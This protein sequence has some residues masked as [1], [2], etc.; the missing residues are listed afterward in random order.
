[1]KNIEEKVG[2]RI[3]WESWEKDIAKIAQTYTERINILLEKDDFEI[4]KIFEDFVNGLKKNLNDSITRDDAI[5]MLS[6]HLITKPVFDALF[7]EYEFV[8]NNPV[9]QA[10]QDMMEVFDRQSLDEEKE[11]LQK[12]YDSVRERVKGIDNIDGKQKIIIELY[13]KFFKVAL[14]KEVEKLGIVYTPTECVDFIVNSVETI[15]NKEFNKSLSDRGIHIM[16]GFTGTG[17]FIVRLLQSGIIKKEDLLYKYTNEIYANEIVLLAYYIAVINIEEVFHDLMEIDIYIPF[18]G[19]VLTD[20]FQLYE[21][22]KKEQSNEIKMDILPENSERARKQKELPITVIMGNPPYS[23]GQKNQDDNAKNLK[24]PKLDKQISETYVKYSNTSLRRNLYD[25]Y[26]R[27]FRWAS[28]RILDKGVICFISNASFI[29]SNTMNGFRKCIIDE[30]TSIYI[31]NLRGN[32]RMSGETSRKEGGKIFGSGSRTPV[33]ITCL[34]KN[35]NRKN[36]GYIHY[37]DIGDYLSR[38]E[39]LF[40]IS[41][42]NNI[43]NIEWKKIVP[44]KN[45]DWI[46]KRNKLFKHLYPLAPDKKC[47]LSTKSVFTNYVIGTVSSRDAW[48]YNYDLEKLIKNIN[49]MLEY[50]NSERTKIHSYGGELSINTNKISWSRGLKKKAINNLDIKFNEKFITKTLYRPFSKQNFY[51][52]ANIIESPG[53]SKD[54]F[55]NENKIIVVPGIGSKKEFSCLMLESIPCL[56]MIEKGQCFPLYWYGVEDDNLLNDRKNKIIKHDGISDSFL[57]K[58]RKKYNHAVCKEDIFFYIYGILHSKQYRN[59]FENDLKKSLPNIPLVET[60][61]DFEIFRDSGKKLSYLHLNYE[62]IEPYKDVKII[63]YKKEDYTVKKMKF[64]KKDK[65]KIIYNDYIT[66]EDIPLKAYEYIVNGKSAIEWIMDR[67]QIKTDKKSGIINNP[68]D[69]CKNVSNHKYIFD[70]LLSIINVSVKSVDI[71]NSL[72]HLNFD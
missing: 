2:S 49:I 25:S 62:I 46:N 16:D 31:F 40:I 67:Y 72:P 50:Y 21:E 35:P 20:T 1:M 3:Y 10:M 5:E 69:W 37:Y 9:S 70:L 7:E 60:Y 26:I 12:F 66:I 39:K 47:D 56:D 14:P 8:R 28:D 11:K 17:I 54:L 29:D 44:D 57:K 33:A 71:V 15:L 4:N 6:Q 61:K 55:L 13:D 53:K 58:C 51:F 68:N 48:V 59:T 36:D 22:W 65:S 18:E 34:V 24:Y 42:K 27:A 23:V 52:D 30:F 19:I 45:N 64:Y 43:S 32:Q 41:E 38:E 63:D